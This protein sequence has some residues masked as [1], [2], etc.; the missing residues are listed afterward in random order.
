MTL[1]GYIRTS[2]H[3]QGWCGWNVPLQPGDPAPQI[4]RQRDD[5]HRDVGVSDTTGTRNGGAGRL[6]GRLV[7]GGTLVVLAIDRIGRRWPDAIRPIC[8][9]WNTRRPRRAHASSGWTL[10][11]VKCPFAAP[12]TASRSAARPQATCSFRRQRAPLFRGEPRPRTWPST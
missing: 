7:G 4:R 12:T 9:L 10:V 2:R 5:I 8:E 11:A 1:F 3:L 6:N